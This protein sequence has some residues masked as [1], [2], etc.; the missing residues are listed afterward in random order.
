LIADGANVAAA[1]RRAGSP[2]VKSDLRALGSLES[3]RIGHSR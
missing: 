2:R 3:A 1:A